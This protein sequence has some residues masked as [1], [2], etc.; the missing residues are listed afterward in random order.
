MKKKDRKRQARLA[1]TAFIRGMVATGILAVAESSGRP[2]SR[3]AVRRALKSGI[4]VA[5]GT[6]VADALERDEPV[7]AML[8]IAG[9]IIAAVTVDSLFAMADQE[10]ERE[11]DGKEEI[12]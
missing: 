4:A 12:G 1:R 10:Q 11:K 3:K 8:A 5:G 9:G 2:L 6:V 7:K